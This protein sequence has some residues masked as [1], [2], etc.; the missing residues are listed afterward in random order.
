M[1]KCVTKTIT[2]DLVSHTMGFIKKGQYPF[3]E[4]IREKRKSC[5][6]LLFYEVETKK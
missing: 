4:F 2:N 6:F 3:D 1:S 5:N